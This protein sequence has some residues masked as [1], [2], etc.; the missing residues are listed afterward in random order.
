MLSCVAFYFVCALGCRLAR[1]FH[2]AL[3]ILK[4]VFLF[5]PLLLISLVWIPSSWIDTFVWVSRG[6]AA[7]FVILQMVVIVDFAYAVNDWFVSQSN[8]EYSALAASTRE[9][10]EGL[11]S[12]FSNACGALGESLATLL[13]ISLFLFAVALTGNILLFVF[14][15]KCAATSAFV[16]MTLV[17]C[18]GTTIVQLASENGNLLTSSAV[19]AYAVFVAYTA[20]SREPNEECNPFKRKTDVLGI[21]I[22]LGLSLV[23]LAWTT[24]ASTTA[25]AG[26]F[27]EE[28]SSPS[29]NSELVS[30]RKDDD[31]DD[32]TGAIR[33]PPPPIEC[34]DGGDA[35]NVRFN[36][37]L[38]LVACYVACSLTN[39]G[40]WRD[41]QSGTDL[42]SPLGGQ[43]SSWLNIASQWFFML[44]YLWTLLAPM[45]FPSRDFS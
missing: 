2:D 22:G 14:F 1:Q 34:L 24:H 33:M 30:R 6:G 4:I 27:D 25:V 35:E 38:S 42:S 32:T 39:W 23:S 7:L 15:S 29:L 13:G 43:V 11:F 28:D 41:T 17:L 10:G 40:T 9:S 31:D 20:V 3:W 45:L 21:V 26:L 37:V 16:A 5:F 19:S 36:M 44:L 18:V 12:L 8:S